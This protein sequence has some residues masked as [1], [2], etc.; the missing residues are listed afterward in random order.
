MPPPQPD[1]D[2]L[3]A[4]DMNG[5]LAEGEDSEDDDDEEDD[6]MEMEEMCGAK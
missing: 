2:S 6:T 4:M 5:L 3:P 1:V